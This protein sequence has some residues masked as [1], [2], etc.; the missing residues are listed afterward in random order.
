MTYSP[1]DKSTSLISIF[2]KAASISAVALKPL[3]ELNKELDKKK[4]IL[5][6]AGLYEQQLRSE[7]HTSELQSPA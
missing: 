3:Q 7:E 2:E 5:Q 4:N 1:V 6:V